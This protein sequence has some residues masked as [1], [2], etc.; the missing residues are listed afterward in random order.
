MCSSAASTHVVLTTRQSCI[1]VPTSSDSNL[2]YLVVADYHRVVT[3]VV[4][5]TAAT[6]VQHD[7]LVVSSHWTHEVVVAMVMMVVAAGYVGVGKGEEEKNQ[8]H[9][10]QGEL[11]QVRGNDAAGLEE[12][13]ES[14]HNVSAQ[15]EVAAMVL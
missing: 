6:V 8:E 9:G 14:L 12:R 10:G 1:T 5:T 4:W 15:A 3:L 7:C 13:D 11:I 2:S